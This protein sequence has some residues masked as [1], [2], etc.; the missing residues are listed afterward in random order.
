MKGSLDL[1]SFASVLKERSKRAGFTLREFEDNGVKKIIL[2]HD[3]GLNWSIYSKIFYEKILNSLG[4]SGKIDVSEN[5]L[6]IQISS[7]S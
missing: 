5:S 4:Y 6:V 3:M 2:Q 7:L 1:D